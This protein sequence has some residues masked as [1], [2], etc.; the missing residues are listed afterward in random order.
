MMMKF[1]ILLPGQKNSRFM[2]ALLN[3]CPL[4]ATIGATKKVFSYKEILDRVSEKF[5]YS[6]LHHEK[7]DTAMKFRVNGHC[8][9][10]AI[11]STMSQPFAAAA[12]V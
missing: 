7:H 5:T 12:T 8:G 6:K 10:F 3:L 9:T 11:I 2:C 4:P 1:W